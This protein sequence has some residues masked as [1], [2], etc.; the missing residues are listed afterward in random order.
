MNIDLRYYIN[1]NKLREREKKDSIQFESVAYI[2]IYFYLVPHRTEDNRRMFA[3][4]E[5]SWSTF[6]TS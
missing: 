2:S 6:P 1:L 3:G 5:Q 4:S